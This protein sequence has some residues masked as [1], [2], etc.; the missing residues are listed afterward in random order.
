MKELIKSL[1]KEVKELEQYK[2]KLLFEYCKSQSKFTEID[3]LKALG[4]IKGI[5]FAITKINELEK[6]VE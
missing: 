1:E 3:Y 2:E 4:K 6:G 5:E